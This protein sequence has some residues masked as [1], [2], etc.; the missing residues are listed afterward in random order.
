MLLAH[1]TDVAAHIDA[2]RAT[3]TSPMAKGREPAEPC[4]PYGE[5]VNNVNV[6][7]LPGGGRVVCRRAARGHCALRAHGI[8]APRAAVL[9]GPPHSAVSL[10]ARA[11]IQCARPRPAPGSRGP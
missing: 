6:A 5:A 3:C 4:S 1:L 9:G 10:A 7:T 8:R 11:G 2:A